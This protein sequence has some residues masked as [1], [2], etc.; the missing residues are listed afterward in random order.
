[1]RDIARSVLDRCNAKTVRSFPC[2]WQSSALLSCLT[3][4]LFQSHFELPKSATFGDAQVNDLVIVAMQ[5][6]LLVSKGLHASW[7]QKF[8]TR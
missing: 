3:F 8:L 2:A 6:P 5:F 7:K 1:M 4:Q